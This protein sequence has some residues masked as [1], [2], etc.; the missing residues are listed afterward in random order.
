M[1]PLSGVTISG[2]VRRKVPESDARSVGVVVAIGEYVN[3]TV[4]HYGF[5]GKFV[6]HAPR[7]KKRTQ[8]LKASLRIGESRAMV[9]SR[10]YSLGWVRI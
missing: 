1:C 7:M 5:E 10:S 2:R 9:C 8:K 3:E 6:F 4:I